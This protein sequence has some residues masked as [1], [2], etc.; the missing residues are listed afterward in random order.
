MGPLFHEGVQPVQMP[1]NVFC[2]LMDPKN[3][4]SGVTLIYWADQN[5]PAVCHLQH[6]NQDAAIQN[7][8]ETQQRERLL[9]SGWD[10][11]LSRWFMVQITRKDHKW[12]M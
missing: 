2:A 7:E 10:K 4:H 5:E 8:L 1:K 11:I 3:K 9:T 6:T 12:K